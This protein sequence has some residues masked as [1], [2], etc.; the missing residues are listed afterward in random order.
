M[1]YLKKKVTNKAKVEGSICEAYLINEITNFVFHYFGDDV[2]TIWNRVPWND[3]G[4]LKSLNGRLSIFSYLGKKLSKRFYRRQLSHDEMQNA[5]N[6]VIF[7][8]QELK[9]YLE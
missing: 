1:F 4:G 5:H 8:C 6:Y 7:N 3:D 2:Q 9:P